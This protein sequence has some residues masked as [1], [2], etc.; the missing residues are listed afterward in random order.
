MNR[1][2]VVEDNADNRLLIQVILE[3]L[4]E[5]RA[6]E[7]GHKGLEGLRRDRPDLLLLDI[8]L[9]DMDGVAVLSEIREDPAL[10]GMPVVALTAHNMKGDRERFLEVGFDDYVTKPIVDEGLLIGVIER[11]LPGRHGL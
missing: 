2:A 9:P 7:D 6:Y 3:D 11:W 8:S 5:L 10:Q 1:V 4:Y